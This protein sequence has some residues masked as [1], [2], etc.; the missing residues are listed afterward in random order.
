MKKIYKYYSSNF[1]VESYIKNPTL[2]LSQL[3][4]LN[5]PFEGMLPDDLM[6]KILPIVQ[7]E[8]Y[9]EEPLSN[10]YR[11]YSKLSIIKTLNEYGV[12]SASETQR[13]LL[14][15]AHYASEHKGVCIGYNPKMLENKNQQYKSYFDNEDV[16]GLKKVNYDKI[17]FDSEH[18]DEITRNNTITDE[19]FDL[20]AERALTTKSDEWSYE[21]EHRYIS[22]IN[23]AEQIIILRKKED[24]AGYMISAINK[25]NEDKSYD[26]IYEKKRVILNSRRNNHTIKT[27]VTNSTCPVMAPLMPSKEVLFLVGIDKSDITS[28]HFG[29]RHDYTKREAIIKEIES[30]DALKHINV[31]QC[32]KST[33]RYELIERKIY[34]A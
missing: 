32:E 27:N 26:V 8:F 23:L 21:K 14:M 7:K 17:S 22:N 31:F 2:R 13:N 4:T 20:L 34:P 15:W 24:L 19:S 30:N 10:T 3:H 28:I 33:N 9:P 6:N 1:D 16:F 5:D 12:A 25:A 29:A 18:I 11:R